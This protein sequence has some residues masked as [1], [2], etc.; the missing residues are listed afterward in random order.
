MRYQR[1]PPSTCPQVP[2]FETVTQFSSNKK[3]SANF[4]QPYALPQ[5]SSLYSDKDPAWPIKNGIE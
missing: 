2:L 1:P 5:N 3:S 4:T